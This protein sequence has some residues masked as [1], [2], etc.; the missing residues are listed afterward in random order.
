MIILTYFEDKINSSLIH[1][2]AG[3]SWNWELFI[4]LVI[5]NVVI[6]G[7]H[8]HSKYMS[9]TNDYIINVKEAMHVCFIVVKF[10]SHPQ[11][12]NCK[13][14]NLVPGHSKV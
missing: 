8:I 10:A 4:L 2:F 13:I 3:R 12:K 11:K 1:F 6:S 14:C 7:H 5:S 9:L